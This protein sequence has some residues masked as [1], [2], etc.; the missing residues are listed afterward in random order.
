MWLDLRHIVQFRHAGG[1]STTVGARGP[2]NRGVTQD[3][4]YAV[5]LMLRAPAFAL[6]AVMTLALGVGANTAIF[7]VVR[8]VLLAPLPFAV[9]ER[10]VSVWHAY[11]PSLPRAAV[12]APGF[13]DLRQASHIFDDVAAF[14][15]SNQNLTGGGEP[16]RLL[17]ARTS[18]SF[19]PVLGLRLAI[20]RWFTS[21]EDVPNQNRVLV[22]SDGLW[23]RRFGAD[24]NVIGRSV[25]L[26]DVSHRVI[27][28][29]MAA[30]TFPKAT[31]A[32]VP[33]AFTPEQRGPAG[34]GS[35]FLDAIARL[36]DGVTV[37][38]AHDAV[39]A[40]ART[41]HQQYYA[42]SPRWTLGMRPVTDDLVRD[43][44]PSVLAVFGAVALVLLIA[45]VNIANLLL[46]RATHRGREFALR[47]ALG[48][49]AARLRQ[50]L[51]IETAILGLLGGIA[52]MLVAVAA[53]PLV[54]RAAATA[55]PRFDVPR[56]DAQAFL[57]AI[58][59]AFASS[60]VFGL[61]PAWQVS[62]SVD[63]RG[64]LGEGTRA[65]AGRA[66][67]RTLV[68]AEIALAF[69]VIVGAG[70]LVRSFARV[71][72][73]DPGFA[74]Q[75]RLTMRVTLPV[76][77]YP[78]PSP[79]LRRAAEASA[80]AARDMARRATFYSQLF[81]RLSRL[82]GV[83]AAGGVSEL[84]LG[85]LRNMGTFDI[86]GQ[87]TPRGQDGPHGD[88][89]SASPG[90]FRAMGIALIRGRVFTDGDGA[91]SPPVAVI[92]EQAARYWVSGDPIGARISIDNP[93]VWREIVGVVRSV[94]HDA[95]DTAPRGTVYFP[96]AQ[97]PTTTVFA[98]VNTV[99]DPE[100]AASSARATVRA[101]DPE[102]PVYDVSSLEHRLSDSLGRR[103]LAMWLLVA[104]GTLALTLA[105]IGVYG[106][107]AYDVGQRKQEIGIRMALGADRGR[108]VHM[109]LA[110]GMTLTM[111]GIALGVVL[112][113]AMASFAAR[114]LFEVSPYDPITYVAFAAVLIATAI[115]AAYI[116]ARRATKVDPMTAL[117]DA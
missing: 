94:R 27:G 26:N 69:S 62:R 103:R 93:D 57:F 10:L 31:D 30:A 100:D 64:A 106:V 40:L 33:I 73:V 53:V 76:S 107:V 38:H 25:S 18:Q 92:D 70:L 50:Q 45:C 1:G 56:L 111:I 49:A 46:A 86:Q 24:P 108:V 82:P 37:A 19:Q 20:G 23:R 60:L 74:V 4:R 63:L 80:E 116:P 11:P 102:L 72:A 5:R 51:F 97:R 87:P 55:F 89:R 43:A 113:A 32:W 66:L 3:I 47:A 104:F 39:A 117:R 12:S 112:A 22:L 42:D 44:R 91:S 88:W 101:L 96:L 78:Q 99:D 81:E 84:P 95:L 90:Y 15:L 109:I 9:P 59:I 67:R 36:R 2:S 34:R 98:V 14:T 68:I 16:E 71:T 13:D 85:E 79:R 21:D 58:A 52:G 17:V 83:S 35:E 8:A 115:A 114:L 28:V 61:V 54:A 65:A 7:S 110:S 6:V 41:L 48:A 29:M 105:A 77:R 75:H